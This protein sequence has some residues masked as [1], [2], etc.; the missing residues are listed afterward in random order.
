MRFDLIV[1]EQRDLTGVELDFAAEIGTAERGDML[2]RQ[3]QHFRVVD[4]DFAD[5]RTQIVAEGTHDDVAF[6]MDQER[7]GAIFRRFFDR[8]PVFQA[9]AQ[10][11][12]QRFGGFADACGAY[13]QSHA[14]RQFQRRER[15]FQLGAI[16]AFDTAR[17]TARARV[18]RHQHQIAAR[19]ADKG[20]QRS[21]FIAAFFFINLNNDF[22]A[23][24]Q[25]IFN[26]GATMGVVA[27]GEILAGNFFKR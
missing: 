8:F 26:V 17:D 10:I 1:A 3:L 2:A 13:D 23:F 24:A 6:L 21:A 5:V 7:R 22:L 14:V 9:E 19:Q 12:L 27:G 11:P 18:V 16:V 20:S 15:L 25:H 4:Q